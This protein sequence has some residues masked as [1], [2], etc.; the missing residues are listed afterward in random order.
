VLATIHSDSESD[1]LRLPGPGPDHPACGLAAPRLRL[2]SRISRGDSPHDY[3][4]GPLGLQVPAG[5]GAFPGRLSD[6][7][8]TGR[9]GNREPTVAGEVRSVGPRES[10]SEVQVG[11]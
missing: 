7:T 1:G 3:H 2:S 5:P 9:P 11:T 10:E 4:D 8:V 6:R